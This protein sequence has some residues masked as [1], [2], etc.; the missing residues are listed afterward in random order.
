M[1]AIGLLG[2]TFDPI[3]Q[4]HLAIAL[5]ALSRLQLDQVRL[6]PCRL[7]PH[8]N[9]PQLSSD[10]R[11]QL[12]HLAAQPHAVLALDDRELKRQGPSYTVDTLRSLRQDLGQQVNLVWIMGMD[13]FVQLE[14]WYQWQ[15]LSRLA[16]LAV[17]Q[18]PGYQGARLPL[19]AEPLSPESLVEFHQKPFGKVLLMDQPQM[20]ISATDIRQALAQGQL[21]K[22]LPASVLDYI[23]ENRLYNFIATT[24]TT[25]FDD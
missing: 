4:G 15:D 24:D 18:R 5:A 13:A 25:E 21:P 3:H 20:D 1:K 14:S 16:H 23:V 19:A 12:I 11:A 17:M 9:R 10:Q 8:R 2:G 7:P 6:L 22:T